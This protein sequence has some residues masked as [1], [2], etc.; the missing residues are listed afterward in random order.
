MKKYIFFSILFFALATQSQA[1]E[2][3]SRLYI[4]SSA[5]T[6]ILK[7]NGEQKILVKDY[8]NSTR[9]MSSQRR[10]RNGHYVVSALRTK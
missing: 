5:Q 3:V 8:L 4:P 1:S 2:S 9:E 7:E 6:T 10:I